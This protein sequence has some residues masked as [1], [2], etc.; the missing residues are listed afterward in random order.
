MKNCD[1]PG[2]WILFDFPTYTPC[3]VPAA[4]G[5]FHVGLSRVIGGQVVAAAGRLNTPFAPRFHCI[6]HTPL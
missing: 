3:A 4:Q 2:L 5:V 6:L 1:M